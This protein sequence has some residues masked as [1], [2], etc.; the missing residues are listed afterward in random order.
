MGCQFFCR[1]RSRFYCGFCWLLL[2]QISLQSKGAT[3][4]PVSPSASLS[5]QFVGGKRHNSPRTCRHRMAA[6]GFFK[7][8]GYPSLQPSTLVAN[9]GE[10]YAA[11]AK[12]DWGRAAWGFAGWS[13]FQIAYVVATARLADFSIAPLI[14]AAVILSHLGRSL[15]TLGLAVLS[16]STLFLLKNVMDL[17][18]LV[19]LLGERP[20]P[21]ET[22]GFLLAQAPL[23]AIA[24]YGCRA[25]Y[26]MLQQYGLP[27]FKLDVRAQKGRKWL[28]T[29]L[30]VGYAATA[31]H[32]VVWGSACL[33][34]GPFTLGALR[35]FIGTGQVA[36]YYK[37][38]SKESEPRR[39]WIS[40]SRRAPAAPAAPVALAP[41]SGRIAGAAPGYYRYVSEDLVEE[42]QQVSLPVMSQDGRRTVP[43]TLNLALILDGLTRIAILIATADKPPALL[44]RVLVLPAVE[45][46]G[47]LG[48]WLIGKS[49]KPS[50]K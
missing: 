46:F 10:G 12:T 47:A 15:G 29:L 49:Y 43:R 20:V 3:F 5:A 38:K 37:S 18:V 11:A 48:G 36:S 9:Q 8:E 21:L 39:T 40:A 35:C 26:G 2:L 23:A 7:G 30:A 4:A 25:G 28:L 27:K 1:G 45:L 19:R 50:E 41:V 44:A 22:E 34:V 33:F 13:S 24:W 6:E 16:A 17:S 31:V 42:D 14:M 32:Q